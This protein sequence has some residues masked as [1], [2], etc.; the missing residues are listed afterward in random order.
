MDNVEAL[1]AKEREIAEKI[2]AIKSDAEGLLPIVDGIIDIEKYLKA[3]YKILWML[4][5]PH[6][7]WVIVRKTGQRRNGGWSLA[8]GYSELT[9]E[10]INKKKRLVARRI[11]EATY[12]ILPETQ[13][14][15]EAFKSV[16]CINI[17]K[18]P[19]GISAD[20]KKIEQAYNEHRDL[21]E[22]QI[23]TYNPDIII[24]GNTLPYLS[25][26]NY[27]V[28]NNRKTFGINPKSRI[29]Y[30]ALKDRLYINI[31]HPAYKPG[32]RDFW[33]KW[34]ENIFNAVSDWEIYFRGK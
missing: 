7:E 34:V 19:G 24:C 25:R 33:N 30:Y 1:K 5:E 20:P 29:C 26:D 28:K 17:K 31:Y 3:K 16:A 21:L 22:E 2:N 10:D 18:I 32:D 9:M 15:L 8:E 6:D 27:F 23:E 13:E 4:K 14:P 12:R 11:M